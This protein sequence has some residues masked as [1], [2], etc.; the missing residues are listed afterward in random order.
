MESINIGTVIAKKRKEKG[1]TQEDLAS[2]LGVSKP[3]VSKWES[4]QSYPDITLLPALAAYF[5]MSVDDLLGYEA[6]M[7]PEDV[8]KL[9]LK[10]ADAFANE[11]FEQVYAECLEQ[12]KAY[13]ACDNLV[14]SMA[15]LLVNHA[16]LAGKPDR[17]KAVLQEAADL[18]EHV[19]ESGSDAVLARLA[20][21]MRAYCDLAL[22]QPAEAINLLDRSEEPM[23]SS[24]V[25][26]AKAY[27]MKG[28]AERAK[29]RLQSYLYK[30]LISLWDAFSDLM[31]LYAD[32]TEKIETYLHKALELGEVFKLKEIHPSLYFKLYL[33]AASLLAAQEQK[34]RT[35][36]IL[37]AYTDL[38]SQKNIF[39][40][41]LK[42]NEFFDRLK[43]YFDSLNL[44]TSAPRSDKLIQKDLKDAVIHNPAFQSLASEERY[45]R[46]TGKL[47]RLGEKVS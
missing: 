47:E 24:E 26:L 25:L 45:Q 6:Q 29:D 31:V 32:D 34:E 9:Y 28:D 11:P 7:S 15:Q 17:M 35:L 2:Y 36:E 14:F 46:L 10:L 41:Q 8:K 43:P 20:L 44:G 16:P 21:S 5:N 13:H 30:N 38:L 12:V 4:R 40:V 27:A 23:L 1:I 37:E 3:A 18:F 22:G 39:P 19:E 33:T 42:G